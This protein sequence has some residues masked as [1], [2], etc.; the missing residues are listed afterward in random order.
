M[1]FKKTLMAT[2]AATLFSGAAQAGL[3]VNNWDLDTSAAPTQGLSTVVTGID[4]MSYLA[5]AKAAKGADVG[6]AGLVG[7]T[8]SVTV[9]GN[10]TQFTNFIAPPAA[11]GAI[12]PAGL[13]QNPSSGICGVVDCFEMTFRLDTTVTVMSV[14]GDDVD[15]DH[16]T[17]GLLSLF[18]DRL[19]DLVGAQANPAS[20]ASFTDGDLVFQ[21]TD[22]GGPLS[23]GNFDVS[24]GDGNDDGH[25]TVTLADSL[26]NVAGLFTKGAFDFGKTVGSDVH[27]DSNFNFAA[28][29]SF[30]AL[31]PCGSS[32][33]DFCATEDGS[34][35]LSVVP[36]PTVLGLL[37]WGLL[38]IGAS[39]RRR[40][41]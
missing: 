34:A 11:L 17:G 38:G 30:G 6:P 37:G 40:R 13:N 28:F 19:D 23:S 7:D 36:E 25:F 39:L 9:L 27:T 2:A 1:K 8:Y 24:T 35:G 33:T 20:A 26:V 3:L 32:I 10:F 41:S 14:T 16:N 18:I 22:D 31:A 29:P 4:E 5:I 21:I 12:T 15:F